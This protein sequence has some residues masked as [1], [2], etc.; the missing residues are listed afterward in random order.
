MSLRLP[1]VVKHAVT[2]GGQLSSLQRVISV[3]FSLSIIPIARSS[4]CGLGGGCSFMLAVKLSMPLA[5]A[6]SQSEPFL[7]H[8]AA[9]ARSETRRIFFMMNLRGNENSSR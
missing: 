4:I 9:A 1:T 8:A 2:S 3:D 7:L 5:I 6:V